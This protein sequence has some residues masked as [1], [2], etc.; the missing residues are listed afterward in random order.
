MLHGAQVALKGTLPR[1][2][3]LDEKEIINTNK[4]IL[5]KLNSKRPVPQLSQEQRKKIA[6]L[7]EISNRLILE[8]QEE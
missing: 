2:K 7:L 1:G 5:R 3:Q 8:D 4:R 6:A